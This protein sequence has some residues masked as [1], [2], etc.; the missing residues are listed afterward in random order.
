VQLTV[1][2]AARRL[3]VTESTVHRWIRDRGLP[4]VRFNEQYRL[5]EVDLQIWAQSHSVPIDP[6]EPAPGEAA[7][8]S[9]AAALERGAI[10]RD[11]P[12]ADHRQ[13]ILAA[14]ERL[15]VAE[16]ADR[17][18]LAEVLNARE[19]KGSTAIGGGIAVPHARYPI[20]L[21]LGLPVL[22]LSFLRHPVEFGAADGQPV[23]TLFTL[24]T[25]TIRVHLQFLARLALALSGEFGRR[26]AAHAGD[27]AIL[28]ALRAADQLDPTPT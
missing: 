19:R 4:A 8:P 15:P 10:H 24:V 25:P 17:T 7:G 6:G 1:R 14:S 20:I 18:L 28:A 12:G 23:H 9:I 22:S 16:T 26:V 21:P 27:D 5:N 11:V 3:H 2:E 13:V